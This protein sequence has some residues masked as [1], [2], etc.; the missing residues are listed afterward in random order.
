[1]PFSSKEVIEIELKRLQEN[2]VV[3]KV[4]YSEWASPNVYVKKKNKKIRVC[5]DFST[6][7]HDCLMD[8]SYLLPSPFYKAEWRKNF[9]QN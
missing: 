6:G 3:E 2:G 5:V 4:D 1:M 9:L 7:L 8:H